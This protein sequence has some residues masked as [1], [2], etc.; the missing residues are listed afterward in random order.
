[1]RH[2]LHPLNRGSFSVPTENHAVPWTLPRGTAYYDATNLLLKRLR[3]ESE[4]KDRQLVIDRAELA[5]AVRD[6]KGFCGVTGKVSLDEG[7]YRINAP[8]PC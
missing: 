2:H 3:K 5:E 1:M 7:G 8:A 4:I 6:T